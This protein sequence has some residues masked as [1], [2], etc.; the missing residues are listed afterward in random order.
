MHYCSLCETRL[1]VAFIC[2][3]WCKLLLVFPACPGD[4]KGLSTFM[5]D[6]ETRVVVTC[7]VSETPSSK[8]PAN[9][10]LSFVLPA[11]LHQGKSTTS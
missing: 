7:D 11:N 8:S 3:L 9:K 5:K 4:V 1:I 10:L 2:E 6:G